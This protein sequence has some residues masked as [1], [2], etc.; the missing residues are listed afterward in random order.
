M[1]NLKSNIRRL[2][3]G[4]F[5]SEF[6]FLASIIVPFYSSLGLSMN[7]IMWTESIFALTLLILEVPSGYFADRFG[8]KLSLVFGIFFKFFGV[9]ILACSY[10]FWSICVAQ[11]VWGLAVGFIS[12]ANEALLFETLDLLGKKDENKKF[13]GNMFFFKRMGTLLASLLC[14]FLSL[15]SLRFPFYMTLIPVFLAFLF[16]LGLREPKLKKEN[17]FETWKHLNLIFREVF[18]KN[19][20]L[21]Y[22]IIFA[23]F[24][25]GF[26]MIEFWM[27]QRFLEFLGLP[28][29]VFPLVV[30]GMNIFAGLMGKYAVEIEKWLSPKLSL[31]LIVLVSSLIW[32]LCFL[33]DSLWLI[34]LLMFT[35]GI[36]GFSQVVFNDF[37]QRMVSDDRRAT[38]LSIMSFMQRGLFFSFGPFLG[39][40]CDLWSVQVAFLLMTVIL[41][42]CSGVCFVLL[43]RVGV[44]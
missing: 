30:A 5:F 31:V 10:S 32:F 14:V 2:Y 19:K 43:R 7:E 13:Q 4:N 25:I 15:V 29:F 26:F 20:K 33:F 28:I 22:F 6:L 16:F 21:R 27:K 18:L 23:S 34:V 17:C 41:L 40:I 24:P 39:W 35:S 44:L 36:W 1:Q 11:I 9:L 3:L 42:V 37:V 8:R 38:V 12:G